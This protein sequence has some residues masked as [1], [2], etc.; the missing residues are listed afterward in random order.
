[1]LQ[2][3]VDRCSCHNVHKYAEIIL[4]PHFKNN[5]MEKFKPFACFSYNIALGMTVSDISV[6]RIKSPEV[7][8]GYQCIGLKQ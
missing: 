4:I 5:I 8:D 3:E 6:F 2:P 7:I 1:M